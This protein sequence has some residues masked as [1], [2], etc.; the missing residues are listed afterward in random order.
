MHKKNRKV[1]NTLRDQSSKHSINF[2][3]HHG[4]CNIRKANMKNGGGGFD[5]E[6]LILRNR[7]GVPLFVIVSP[8]AYIKRAV[9]VDGTA[10][11]VG[12]N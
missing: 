5:F 10:L 2:Y 8:Q 7:Y 12:L 4:T 9:P 6:D 3:M 11:L 1:K